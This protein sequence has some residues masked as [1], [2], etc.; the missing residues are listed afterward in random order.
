M[1]AAQV[2]ACSGPQQYHGFSRPQPPPTTSTS[3]AD[4]VMFYVKYLL[5]SPFFAAFASEEIQLFLVMLMFC[6]LVIF[7]GWMIGGEHLCMLL[8]LK[9]LNYY[10]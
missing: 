2:P 7:S 6:F 10:I 1:V 9:S 3:G 8:S 5:S 4:L